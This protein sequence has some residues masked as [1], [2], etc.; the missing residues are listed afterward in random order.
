MI[1][2]KIKFDEKKKEREGTDKKDSIDKPSLSHRP[3]R[4]A[5]RR[6]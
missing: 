3:M 5:R 6:R 2:F 4:K 1:E